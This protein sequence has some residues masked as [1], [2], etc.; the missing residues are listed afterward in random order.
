MWI[1]QMHKL[2][3]G[4]HRCINF[5]VYVNAWHFWY[6]VWTRNEDVHMEY[7]MRQTGEEQKIKNIECEKA[8][9]GRKSNEMTTK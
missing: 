4:F 5:S 8:Y 2:Q 7:A 3:C 9:E 6:R 1:S